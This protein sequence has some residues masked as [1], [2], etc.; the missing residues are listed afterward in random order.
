MK[1]QIRSYLVALPA[2]M[3]ALSAHAHSPD[4]HM[5]A[6]QASAPDCSMMEDMDH[7]KM[8][9]NDPVMQAMMKKCMQTMH[10]NEGDLHDDKSDATKHAAH[11]H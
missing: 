4:K 2:L 5:K 11:Q 10:K 9:M 6:A 3:L 7:S 8:N 1:P